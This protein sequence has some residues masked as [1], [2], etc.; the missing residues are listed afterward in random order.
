MTKANDNIDWD[1]YVTL[2]E[3]FDT[4]VNHLSEELDFKMTSLKEA[5]TLARNSMDE[6]LARMNEFREA[7]KDQNSTF[8]TKA[9]FRS[10]CDRV[11][12]ELDDLKLS[13]AK[14]EGK[15]EQSSVNISLILAVIGIAL[16]ISSFIGRLI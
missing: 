6:R 13:K 14:L 4:K 1:D 10:F 3:Y 7:L 9:E 12:I 11:T 16:A 2:K 15:A 8:I 5:T